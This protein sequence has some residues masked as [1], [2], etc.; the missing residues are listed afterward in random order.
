MRVYRITK[1]RKTADGLEGECVPASSPPRARRL[2]A[3]AAWINE[4]RPELRATVERSHV[5]TD[6]KLTGTR[7][8]HPG[9]GRRGNR[10][11]VYRLYVSP[12]GRNEF[13]IHLTTAGTKPILDHDSAET[14]RTNS[15]V[16][17]WLARYLK[18]CTKGKHT[19]FFKSDPTCETCGARVRKVGK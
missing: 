6:R 2:A 10:I 13:G 18:D 12:G 16:E 7:L 4:N 14:Y 5:S 8:R 1:S 19:T 11:K 15:E 3:I 9:K 17:E